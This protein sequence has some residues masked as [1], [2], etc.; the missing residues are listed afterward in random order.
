MTKWILLDKELAEIQQEDKVGKT[1][2][3]WALGHGGSLDSVCYFCFAIQ[4]KLVKVFLIACQL[5]N[6]W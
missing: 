6:S 5:S 1:A 2:Q 3:L 4:M